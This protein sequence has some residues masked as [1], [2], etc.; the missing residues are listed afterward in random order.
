[1]S[2]FRVEIFFAV[3][4]LIS[5]TAEKPLAL[6]GKIVSRF[7]LLTNA[8][9]QFPHT[10]VRKGAVMALGQFCSGFHS[11]LQEAGAEDKTACMW[12]I[13]PRVYLNSFKRLFCW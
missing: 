7:L 4:E 3:W 13:Q 1:M 11:L 6:L 5:V 9:R 12:R 8:T 2:F 10:G